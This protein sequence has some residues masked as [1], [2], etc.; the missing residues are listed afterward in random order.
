MIS[1]L[2]AGTLSD[3]RGRGAVAFPWI[4]LMGIGVAVF[5]FL[6]VI[7]WIMY[8]ASILAGFGYSGSIAVLISWVIDR[9]PQGRTTT[10]LALQDSAVDIGIGLGSFFFGI[11]IPVIGMNWSYGLSG[12]GL[13]IFALWQI[14]KRKGF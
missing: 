11:V 12:V 5:Y 10:A 2:I 9:A 6:P 1:N 4:V 13:L 14:N 7:P 3:R 8:I